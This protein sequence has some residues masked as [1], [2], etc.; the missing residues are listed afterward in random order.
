[1]AGIKTL[2][3]RV[4]TLDRSVAPPAA[5]KRIDGNSRVALIRRLDR[6][7]ARVCAACLEYGRVRP[8]VELDHI[9]PLWAGGSND[10]ANLQ[11][12]CKPCHA[13][14]TAREARERGG[15]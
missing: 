1:M 11:W 8:G 2:R 5:T 4:R 9:A 14:K 15:R 7:R 12:L 6:E 13:A 10:A 3:P